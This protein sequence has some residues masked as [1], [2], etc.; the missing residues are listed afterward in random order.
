MGVFHTSSG[1]L[2]R[3]L[4]DKLMNSPSPSNGGED[5]SEWAHDPPEYTNKYI[6]NGFINKML[7]DIEVKLWMA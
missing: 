4:K 2:A 3:D 1:T 7:G 6:Y 5:M